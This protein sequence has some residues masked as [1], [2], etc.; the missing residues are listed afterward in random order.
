ML[1]WQT[2]FLTN[3]RTE[4]CISVIPVYHFALADVEQ[5]YI[6]VYH[7]HLVEKLPKG[8]RIYYNLFCAI[9]INKGLYFTILLPSFCIF[10]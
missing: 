3:K 7:S 4:A 10:L 2:L 5:M 8:V 9:Y 6:V 1:R